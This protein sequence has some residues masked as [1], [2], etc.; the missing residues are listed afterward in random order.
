MLVRSGAYE[1]DLPRRQL[2]PCYWPASRHRCLRGT[3]FVEKG[4]E[5]VPL[6]VN[7]RDACGSGGGAAGPCCSSD[8]AKLRSGP[9]DRCLPRHAPFQ[10][11]HHHHRH[12]LP[13]R[14]LRH[15]CLYRRCC[16]LVCAA[17]LP[18]LQESLAEQVEEGFRQAL[19]LPQRGRL[20]AQP[21]GGYAAR[22]DLNTSVEKGLYALFASGG[23]AAVGWRCGPLWRCG[24]GRGCSTHL[25]PSLPATLR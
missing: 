16:T 3:W 7:G 6:K 9:R 4:G 8:P 19:W 5:W 18:P 17:A 1:V 24:G 25:A 2:R 11:S 10:P 13:R 20:A 21:G 23:A 22:L 12:A 15:V 14:T